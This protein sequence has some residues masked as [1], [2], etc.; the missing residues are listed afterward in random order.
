MLM[1][2]KPIRLFEENYLKN[3]DRLKRCYREDKIKYPLKPNQRAID[4]VKNCSGP[5]PDKNIVPTAM[6]YPPFNGLICGIAIRRCEP[7]V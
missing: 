5:L 1:R 2:V 4:N 3:T 7:F 6:K